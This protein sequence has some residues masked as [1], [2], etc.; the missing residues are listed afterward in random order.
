MGRGTGSMRPPRAVFVVM[1]V[2]LLSC[3]HVCHVRV[4]VYVCVCARACSRAPAPLARGCSQAFFPGAPRTCLASDRLPFRLSKDGCDSNL[5]AAPATPPPPLLLPLPLL[6]P[7]R[8]LPRGAIRL[9]P[10][11]P[12]TRRWGGPTRLLQGGWLAALLLLLLLLLLL[13]LLLAA[14]RP[15]CSALPAGKQRVCLSMLLC[16]CQHFG[17]G[18][19]ACTPWCDTRK[20]CSVQ[21]TLPYD[22]LRCTNMKLSGSETAESPVPSGSDKAS[23]QNTCMC[24]YQVALTRHQYKLAL[25]RHQHNL[26]LTRHQHKTCA[27]IRTKITRVAPHTCRC[28]LTQALAHPLAYT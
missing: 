27:S 9:V 17:G 26:A 10:S 3:A 4:C 12:A 2:R 24:T 6:L 15:G 5:G 16:T 18:T 8:E 7:E 22:T 11:I 20:N 25:T 13:P 23:V 14:P 28:V 21:P 1:H 19:H